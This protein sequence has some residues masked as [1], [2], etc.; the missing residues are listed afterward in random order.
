M[1]KRVM[2][3]ILCVVILVTSGISCFAASVSETSDTPNGNTI[4]Y[5]KSEEGYDYGNTAYIIRD[6]ETKQIIPLSVGP[7]D[8]YS[9]AYLPEN[10]DFTVEKVEKYTTPFNDLGE[11]YKYDSYINEI[12]AREVVVGFEDGSFKPDKELTRAE[13]ATIFTRMFSVPKTRS[14]SCFEDVPENHWAK[15]YIM[16]LVDKG[17]FMK[18]T[19]FNPDF[20]ITREQLV[21]MTFRMLS[22]MG[23][24]EPQEAEMDFSKYKDLDKV[25][26]YAKVAYKALT[27]DNYHLLVELVDHEF[28]DTADDELFWY[29]QQAVTR[30]E[31][32]EFLYQ[33]IRT[34][35]NNHAPAILKDTAPQ[36]EIPVLDGS[37]STYAITQNIY[38]AYYQN[39]DN[40]PDFPKSHSKTVASYK[41]LIDGEVE[42]I[43]V[44]DAGEEVLKYAE[45][46]NVKLKFIPIADEA[47]IF[48]TGTKN[49]VDNITTEQLHDIYVNNGIT[50]WKELGGDD[51]TL[52]A[53]C[54]NED[55][56]SH[57]QMEQFVLAGEEI[58]EDISRE[59]TS[60]MMSSILTE[61]DDYNQKN[62][63]NYANYAMGYSLFYY[64]LVNS[65]VLGPLDLKFLSIDGIAPTEETI[66]D[67]T[68]PYTTSYYAVIRD[69][70]NNPKVDAFAELMQGEFGQL[71][72]AQS[73]L[74]VK[75]AY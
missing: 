19:N 6:K 43:F 45:E 49:K 12:T 24:I 1:K 32:C 31:C 8:G 26:D 22:D 55:S 27:K 17:V 9:Y 35:F 29:P 73:G 51:G 5:L 14:A 57:A 63:G 50:N 18:D 62:E 40:H 36:I 65:S 47:L 71:I 60:I 70:E 10:S 21:A 75:R 20:V 66:S 7:L 61:V 13:M 16:A 46:K 23:K 2:S 59:R 56:G 64:Y 72:A 67:G 42:M 3:I 58:N 25:S 15:E 48:F 37:T 4:K 28:M 39:Y 54:R 30:L 41:R 74:G 11:K 33:F 34:F 68:Y 52:A 44:P 53:Y 69:G 38:S